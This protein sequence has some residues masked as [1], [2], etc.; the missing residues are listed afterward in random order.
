MDNT[1]NSTGIKSIIKE[2]LYYNKLNNLHEMDKFLQT[3]NLPRVDHEEIEN[4]NRSITI[5]K[6]ESVTKNL[7]TKK[8]L[9]PDG[10]LYW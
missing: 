9:R 4:A 8:K 2:Y 10:L 3:H 1:T 6:T 5:R 7:P